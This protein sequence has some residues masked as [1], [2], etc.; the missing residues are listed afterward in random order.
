VQVREYIFRSPYPQRVQ[1][2]MPDNTLQNSQNST[3]DTTKL[4]QQ[5]TQTEIVKNQTKS[6]MGNKKLTP[7]INSLDV[8]A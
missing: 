3:K 7:D 6:I 8:Y 4:E 1:V 5:K 2:G